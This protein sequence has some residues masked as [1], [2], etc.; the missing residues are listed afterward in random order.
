MSAASE[1]P[2]PESSAASGDEPPRGLPSSIA[3]LRAVT[4]P[5]EVRNRRNAEHWTAALYLRDLSPYLTRPL[6]R[7]GASANSVTVLMILTGWATAAV[8]LIP[9]PVGALLALF[10][11][12]LQ[13][14]FDCSDGEVARWRRTRSPLG[15][16]LDAVGHYSTELLI[17]LA[18]GIRA[19]GWPL[20]APDDYGWL[21]LGAL[22]ALWLV[23]NKALNDMVRVARAQAGLTV[24]VSAAEAQPR[25][26]L[27][28]LIRR[29]ARIL[30]LH[31]VLHSVELTMLIAATAVLG[32]VVGHPQADQWLL[33]VL[34][35][36]A[37]LVTCGH[38]VAIVSSGRLR[39]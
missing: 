31:R 21:L 13:M 7:L 19:A 37:L 12:Q 4:Q 38:F 23:L 22:L 6:L 25:A 17:A 18:L 3:E 14:L 10:L 26:G 27:L 20:H 11:G 33:L 29:A 2:L 5:P 9:G 28:A 39:A 8:L 35:P 36:V 16:F 30:P 1:A 34:A 24:A 15:P 32:L